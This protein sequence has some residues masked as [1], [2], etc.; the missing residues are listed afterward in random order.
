[1]IYTPKRDVPTV[2]PR[3]PPS[4]G[5]DGGKLVRLKCLWSKRFFEVKKN[6]IFPFGM[7]FLL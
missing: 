1:M 4:Q 3:K 2:Q 6:G 7:S 5:F